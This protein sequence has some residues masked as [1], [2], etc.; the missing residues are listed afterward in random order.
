[1]VSSVPS[2][3]GL[4]K[5]PV[6][7]S[8]TLICNTVLKKIANKAKDNAPSKIPGR[9]SFDSRRNTIQNGNVQR[10][11]FHVERITVISP[12]NIAAKNNDIK[13]IA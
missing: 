4:P 8:C 3:V 9:N 13:K 5:Y 6:T 7:Q 11:Y 10:K 2:I 1:M 12:Y